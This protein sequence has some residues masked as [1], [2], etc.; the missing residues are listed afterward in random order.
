MNIPKDWPI[1]EFLDIE[2][3]GY[4]NEVAE[5]TNNDPKALSDVV[6]NLSILGRDNAR[7]PMQWD[8]SAHGG[9]TTAEKPW[10]RVNDSYTEINVARQLA[11]PDSVFKFWQSMIKFRKAHADLLVYG[12]FEVLDA[13]NEKTF[14]FVKKHAGEKALVALSFS[15]EDQSIELPEDGNYVFQV[16]NYHRESQNIEQKKPGEVSKVG[17]RPWEAQVYIHHP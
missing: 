11:E 3:R 5:A 17:L 10:M 7:T 13:E 12:T 15:S 4:Y 14:V 2:G 9:F 6:K 16:G 1:E 8:N